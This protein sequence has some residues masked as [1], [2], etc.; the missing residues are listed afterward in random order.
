MIPEGYNEVF[1]RVQKQYK[2]LIGS[3]SK[4]D[5]QVAIPFI[6]RS[7]EAARLSLERLRPIVSYSRFHLI[8]EDL[9][10]NR[11]LTPS[12]FP[13]PMAFTVGFLNQKKLENMYDLVT[14]SIS[15]K[16]NLLKILSASKLYFE[17]EEDLEFIE[18][19][20][21]DFSKGK[22]YSSSF[23]LFLSDYLFLELRGNHFVFFAVL[24]GILL[25]QT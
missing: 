3:V 11:K 7:L 24:S 22:Y 25:Y 15:V 23:F 13:Y 2:N 20:F 17:K 8:L 6:Q 4:I 5:F 19:L 9:R 18:N 10:N 16:K 14:N 21:R 12:L 1:Q